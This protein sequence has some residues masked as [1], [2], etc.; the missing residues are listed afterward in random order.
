MKFDNLAMEVLE[1][2]YLY[3]ETPEQMFHRVAN[4]LADN[5]DEAE[6][7]YNIMNSLKFL[8]NSPTL[9]NAGR[10]LGQLSACFVIPI[11]D[12]MLSICEALKSQAI[13]HKSGG[14]TGFSFSKLRP[15]GALVKTTGGQASGPISF[16]QVFDAMTETVKQGGMR[17]GANMGILHIWHP[18]IEKFITCKNDNNKINNFN[19]SV[20]VTDEF[21]QAVHNEKYYTLSGGGEV[22]APDLFDKICRNA[23]KNGDPGVIFIDTINNNNPISDDIEATN[24]CGEQPLLPYESCCL[25]SI[26][27]SKFYT[28]VDNTIDTTELRKVI[29]IAVTFL[30]K[31]IDKNV[32]PLPEIKINSQHYRRIGLGV[33]G[34]ADLLIKMGIRYDSQNAVRI[35]ENLSKFIN[36]AAVEKSEIL[37]KDHGAFPAARCGLVKD[38]FI[39]YPRYNTTLTTIA[40][41]GTLSIIAGC[42][43]GIEPIFA[44]E[45]KRRHVDNKFDF[46]HPLWALRKELDLEEELFVTAREIDY[47][48]H[49]KHQIA[50]QKYFQNAVSKT[51]NLP[52][53]AT[54]DDVKN[55]YMNA[56]KQGCKGITIYRDHSRDDQPLQAAQDGEKP[57]IENSRARPTRAYGFTESVTVGC[58]KLYITLNMGDDNVPIEMFVNTD[59]LGGCTAQ[60]T[61]IGRLVSGWLQTNGFSID[62]IVDKLRGIKCQACTNKGLKV[63]SCPDAIGRILEQYKTVKVEAPAEDKEHLCPQCKTGMVNQSGCWTCINCGFSFCG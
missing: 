36:D 6:D 2:R 1:K 53:E 46:V 5:T 25:G 7:F 61:A 48:W 15:E 22:Y 14:G 17:R 35:A 41:T 63:L 55:I 11:E 45:M 13:I 19:I 32:Y 29:G 10:P 57:T 16:M 34:W 40:P 33:M 54:V 26:N 8:P 12:D 47:D 4:Y 44:T 30:N 51:I 62:K 43:S 38:G 37:A 39:K 24:P 3:G 9:A 58:G 49:L 56:W 18:D 28:P 23:W 20:A 50:W 59:I 21:M 27:L 42:S 31:I 52:T 60:S